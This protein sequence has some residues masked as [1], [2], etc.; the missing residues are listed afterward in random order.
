MAMLRTP[1]TPVTNVRVDLLVAVAKHCAAIQN[2]HISYLVSIR[3]TNL[4]K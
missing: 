3:G 2:V 1:H 4:L